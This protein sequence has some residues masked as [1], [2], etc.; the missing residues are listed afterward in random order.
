M[1][2]VPARLLPVALTLLTVASVQAQSLS[3]A[4]IKQIEDIAQT[5]ASQ[6]NQNSTAML[7]DMTVSS[8]AIAVGRNVRI[9]NV[10]RVKKGLPPAKLKEFSDETQREIVPRSCSVN[11]NNPAFDRGLFYTF[12]Y[13]NTYG[14]RL[15]EFNVDKSICKLRR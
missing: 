13:L 11:A 2:T 3:P 4:Q 5:I 8:R 12:A 15:A 9:E 10:L 7:D 14:E 6:H 1:N